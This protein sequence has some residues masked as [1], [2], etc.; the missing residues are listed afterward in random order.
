MSLRATGEGHISSIVFRRGVIDKDNRIII[1]TASPVSRRLKIVEDPDFERAT[2]RQT[3][4]DT[5]ALS[6]FA[7]SVLDRLGERFTPRELGVEIERTRQI[8]DAP[9]GWQE[10]LENMFC[11]ARSNYKM[12]VPEDAEASE[13]VIFP[14]SENE[15]RGIEDLRLVRFT[16]EDGSMCYYGT[17]TAFN[18]YKTFPTLLETHDFRNLEIHTMNGR[19]AKNK[20]MALFLA[21]R[22][23]KIVEDPDFE[24]ATFRQTL[25]DTGAL[26]EFA[27]SVLDRLGERFTPRELG[28]EIERT[29]QIHDAPEGWQEC[30]ENMFCVARSNYKMIVPEDAEASEIVIFPMSENESRGIEDLRL[31]R[32]TDDDGSVCYYGTPTRRSSR[33]PTKTVSRRVRPAF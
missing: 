3:L 29:R 19:H 22:P 16:D 4:A 14:M 13:I 30:L 28:V 5:G 8:H 32:F 15:S 9:E 25:A 33:P 12:I 6:E 18:G 11:V 27:E 24:R 31:V 20:G 1:E 7:E 23:L 21:C 2:F 17:Y 26:S 10:C